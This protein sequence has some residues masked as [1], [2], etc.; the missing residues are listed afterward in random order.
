MNLKNKTIEELWDM[1]D[2][3]NYC[4]MVCKEYDMTQAYEKGFG[5][6]K[7]DIHKE[8]IRREK[9]SE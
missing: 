2:K 6:L 8:I 1:L 5:E 7:Y 4:R 9:D 3:D